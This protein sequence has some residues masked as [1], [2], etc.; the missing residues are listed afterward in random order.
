MLISSLG[1]ESLLKQTTVDRHGSYLQLN[2]TLTLDTTA[3]NV[4]SKK[5]YFSP[6]LVTS[7]WLEIFDKSFPP[8]K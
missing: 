5:K 6:L 7:L 8:T 4:A 2:P 3:F 1:F